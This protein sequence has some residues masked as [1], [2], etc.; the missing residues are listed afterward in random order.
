M[1]TKTVLT[2]ADYFKTESVNMNKLIRIL[3]KIDN[4]Q[5]GIRKKNDIIEEIYGDDN[6]I[7]LIGG[8]IDDLLITEYGECNWTNI[9]KLRNQGFEVY[10]KSQDRYG[11]ISG[12]IKTKMGVIVY[13]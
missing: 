13:G 1:E 7:A 2:L 11:W 5:L 4:G 3:S 6:D 10:A 8:L 12:C 9:D